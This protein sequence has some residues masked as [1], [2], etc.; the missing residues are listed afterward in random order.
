MAQQY[1]VTP[2]VYPADHEELELRSTPLDL[3]DALGVAWSMA[4]RRGEAYQVRPL[5]ESPTMNVVRPLIGESRYT[6]H[7]DE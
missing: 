2:Q 3:L 4:R 6:V 1:I 5:L 7:P